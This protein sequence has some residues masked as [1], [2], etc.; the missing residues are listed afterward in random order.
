M[1]NRRW[2]EM[3]LFEFARTIENATY[4]NDRLCIVFIITF[5]VKLRIG[6]AKP[7]KG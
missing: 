7:V 2:N 4:N 1:K 5:L 3:N 6:L